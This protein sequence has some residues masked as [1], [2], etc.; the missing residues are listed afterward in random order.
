M[1]GGSDPSWN[2]PPSRY[3][4]RFCWLQGDASGSCDLGGR[5]VCCS[6]GRTNLAGR[7]INLDSPN[8]ALFF[9]TSI[10]S[11]VSGVQKHQRHVQRRLDRA[12]RAER[13][14]PET[15]EASG[16]VENV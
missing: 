6:F 11:I 5:S 15:T 13:A 7:S 9:G 8:S 2:R 16:A 3:E 4:V 10:F 12:N 14:A 1:V